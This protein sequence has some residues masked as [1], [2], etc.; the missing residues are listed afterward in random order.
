MKTTTTL[1][2]AIFAALTLY[3]CTTDDVE[4]TSFKKEMEA[5]INTDCS[6]SMMHRD[7]ISKD[8]GESDPPTKPIIVIVKP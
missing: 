4:T 1:I 8:V 7:S 2:M 6:Q 3:S 5:D